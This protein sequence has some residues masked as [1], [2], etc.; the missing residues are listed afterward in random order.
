MAKIPTDGTFHQERPLDRL[1]G[2]SVVDSSDLSAA[3]DRLP[4]RLLGAFDGWS[5]S[6]VDLLRVLREIAV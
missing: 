6:L 4:L 5:I 2:S 3:T 1:S